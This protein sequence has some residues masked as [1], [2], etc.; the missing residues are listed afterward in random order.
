MPC[1][2]NTFTVASTERSSGCAGRRSSAPDAAAG[3]AEQC[4]DVASSASI[5]AAAV[6][7]GAGRL[8]CDKRFAERHCLAWSLLVDRDLHRR[9]ELALNVN[10]PHRLSLGPLQE[11]LLPLLAAAA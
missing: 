5:A 1:L 7:A 4:L 9:Y 8:V 11:W 6:L 3:L 2:R 10:R